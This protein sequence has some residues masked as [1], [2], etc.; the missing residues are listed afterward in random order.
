MNAIKGLFGIWPWPI[1]NLL[2]AIF[3][4]RTDTSAIVEVVKE[5]SKVSPIS[6]IVSKPMQG[7]VN[8]ETWRWT[9]YKGR[10]QTITVSRKLKPL[11]EDQEHAVV[12]S[13]TEQK[14]QTN[15]EPLIYA[16]CEPMCR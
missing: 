8:S 3:G 13:N 16:K 1:I 9:D 2:V 15:I 11:V 14:E 10:E 6:T 12:S 7:M 4:N 5:M